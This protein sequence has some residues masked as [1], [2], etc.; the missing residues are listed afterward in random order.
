M[1]LTGPIEQNLFGQ[2]GIYQTLNIEKKSMPYREYRKKSIQHE[3]NFQG[4][5]V[6]DIEDTV[7]NTLMQFWKSVAFSPPLYGADIQTALMESCAGAW[8]LAKLNS[9]LSAAV[10]Q[11]VSGV[12]V[13]YIYV[14]SWK[15]LFCWH[16]EDMD[17][18]AINFLHM[19]KSK[20]WYSIPSSQ[21]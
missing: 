2:A 7:S 14:G 5:E 4:K 6:K 10:K 1:L 16:K 13:P 15:A 21:G 18:S 20:F 12:N 9:L 19:G 11:S 17:L 3:P 8:N